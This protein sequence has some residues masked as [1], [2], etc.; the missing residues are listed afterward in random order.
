MAKLLVQVYI[1]QRKNLPSN[2][3]TLARSAISLLALSNPVIFTV[4]H[5]EFHCQICE[6]F[7]RRRPKSDQVMVPEA[8]VPLSVRNDLS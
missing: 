2:D 7:T 1:K 3:A 6:M 8:S 5:V 4:A